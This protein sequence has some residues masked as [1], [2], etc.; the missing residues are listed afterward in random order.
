MTIATLGYI[1]VLVGLASAG[2]LV[3][4]GVRAARQPASVGKA[5]IRPAVW[6]LVAG[7]ATAFASLE[8][9]LIT[10]DFS[11]KY[12]AEHHSRAT[13]FLFKL[14]TAWAALEGSIV[15]WGLVLA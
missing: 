11:I 5:M 8:L 9:A 7:G 6:G 14:A 10:N 13:P 12:V 3:V 1:G 4:L 2:Y 15:L